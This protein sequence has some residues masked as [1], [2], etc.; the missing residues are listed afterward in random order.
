[1]ATLVPSLVSLRAEI[2]RLCPDRLTD[3]DGWIGDPAHQA[4]QSD[5]NPDSRG[6]V[7]A[8]DVDKDL[9]LSDLTMATV[10][11]FIV[12]RCRANTERRL[13]YVIYQRQIWSA[14]FG[15]RVRPYTGS[16]AHTEHAHFSASA[17]HTLEQS[18]VSWHLEEIP[19][20]LTPADR[21]LLIEVRDLIKALPKQVWNHTEPN[22]EDIDPKT[23][24]ERPGRMGGWARMEL[25]RAKQRHAE[26]LA[27]IAAHH[28]DE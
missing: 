13:K 7:H 12:A 17:D 9:R 3:S 24:K 18:R 23:G 8:L 20:S 14:T 15:W 5:H 16:N 10:V 11:A 26:V 1:M 27:A 4:K 2:D 28:P 19:V 21:A 25:L 6:L 22:P